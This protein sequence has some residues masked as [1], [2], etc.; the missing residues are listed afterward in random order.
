MWLDGTVIDSYIRH[1]INQRNDVVFVLTVH[2][3]WWLVK[4]FHQPQRNF[5]ST[6]MLFVPIN[7]GKHWVLQISTKK[8]QK[9]MDHPGQPPQDLFQI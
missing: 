7:M 5:D 8:T 9:H 3:Q 2:T 6:A 1:L 4:K